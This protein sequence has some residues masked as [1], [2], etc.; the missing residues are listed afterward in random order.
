[1]QLRFYSP[2]HPESR[3]PVS[4][5]AEVVLRSDCTNGEGLLSKEEAATPVGGFGEGRPQQR[6]RRALAAAGGGGG[7]GGD[8]KNI[9][10]A[11]QMRVYRSSHMDPAMAKTNPKLPVIGCTQ[12]DSIEQVDGY[13]KFFLNQRLPFVTPANPDEA[14]PFANPK[15]DKVVSPYVQ[16]EADDNYS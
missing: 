9:Y 2:L 5:Y 15:L 11:W 3:E 12:Y 4:R 16:A 8:K 1:M 7:G 14:M 6:R 10:L 13:G